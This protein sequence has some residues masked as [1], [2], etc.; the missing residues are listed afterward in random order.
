[1]LIA[2]LSALNRLSLE[3]KAPFY[4]LPFDYVFF[5]FPV[6]PKCI[7]QKAFLLFNPRQVL[8]SQLRFVLTKKPAKNEL[9]QTI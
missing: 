4:F 2:P 1:M 6:F 9:L 3:L 5:P 7:C 8:K